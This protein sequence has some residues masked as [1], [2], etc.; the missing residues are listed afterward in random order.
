MQNEQKPTGI[1]AVIALAGL[2]AGSLGACSQSDGIDRSGA[3]FEGI[4]P[5]ATITLAGTEPFWS[6]EI[7]PQADGGYLA[8]FSSPDDT[9]ASPFAV[10]RFAGNNGLGFTGERDG[11]T[12]QI[13]ITPGECSDNMSDATYPFTATVGLGEQTLFGCGETDEV[14]ATGRENS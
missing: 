4:G 7:T 1:M 2:L 3:V 14:P 9:D 10:T 6:V 12:V 13:A 5:G 8:R 11:A